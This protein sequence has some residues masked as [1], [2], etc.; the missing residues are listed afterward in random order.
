M[1]RELGVGVLVHDVDRAAS[2]HGGPCA[3]RAMPTDRY[4][5]HA[6]RRPAAGKRRLEIHQHGTRSLVR[7]FSDQVFEL[8]ETRAD[9]SRPG[10]DEVRQVAASCLDGHLVAIEA[11]ETE[12]GVGLE[13][14]AQGVTPAAEGGVDVQPRR[15]L[16]E[17]VDHRSSSTGTCTKG[18]GSAGRRSSSD[19]VL[20]PVAVDVAPAG[21]RSG[22]HRKSSEENLSARVTPASSG[23]R[24]TLHLV[25]PVA[26]VDHHVRAGTDDGDRPVDADQTAQLGPDGDPVLGVGA[27]G[28]RVRAQDLH[29]LYREKVLL[30]SRRRWYFSQPSRVNSAAEAPR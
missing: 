10:H 14:Q 16:T 8:V 21:Y 20:H 28:T 7:S 18:W 12:A 2:A 9:E 25:P 27:E 4:G 19:T 23:P 6:R 1:T 26:G 15:D 13:H 17:E 24:V 30:S 3:C 11:Q 22:D 5:S 29:L